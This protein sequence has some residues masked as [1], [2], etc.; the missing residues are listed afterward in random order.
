MDWVADKLIKVD[1]ISPYGASLLRLA[2]AHQGDGWITEDS[3]ESDESD[4]ETNVSE[5]FE[6]GA[7][8][9]ASVANEFA[10]QAR[11]TA[12]EASSKAGAVAEKTVE[13]SWDCSVTVPSLC[14]PS[15]CHH[16]AI[17]WRWWKWRAR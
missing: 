12:V 16:C 17:T 3:D 9:M 1:R 7:E 8:T 14:H 11:A 4:E 2:E 13:V 5:R 10:D 6:A 15:L